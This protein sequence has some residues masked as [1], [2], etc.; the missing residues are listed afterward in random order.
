M[1]RPCTVCSHPQRQQIDAAL[2]EHAAG[3]RILASRFGVSKPS[4]QRHVETHLR[5][6]IQQSEELRRML[7]TDNLTDN[8][9]KWHRRMERQYRKA[10][11]AGNVPNTVA[12]A[13]AGIAAIEA[14]SRIGA[15]GELEQR[16][17]TLEAG[18]AEDN[19]DDGTR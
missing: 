1:G 12:T 13:R 6:M 17:A 2:L 4:L 18:K 3:Y 7:A 16:V 14:F 5:G 11:A 15:L 19:P 10:D 8:L 9:A